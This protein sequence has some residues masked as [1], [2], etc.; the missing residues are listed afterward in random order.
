MNN[1][2]KPGI[3]SIIVGCSVKEAE[4]D[5]M[6]K[7]PEQILS[8]PQDTNVDEKDF[9]KPQILIGRKIKYKFEVKK[10]RN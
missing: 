4:Y 8:Y 6:N 2:Y 7:Y 1:N 9:Y 5:K 10:T 3:Y